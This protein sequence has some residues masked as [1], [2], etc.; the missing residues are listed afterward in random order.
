MIAVEPLQFQPEEIEILE[1]KEKPSLEVWAEEVYMIP[2]QSGA[3]NPGPWRNFYTPYLIEPMQKL[4]QVG[5]VQVTIQSCTQWGK[6]ELSNIFVCSRCELDPGPTMILMPREDDANERVNVRLRPGFRAMPKLLRHLP[7]NRAESLNSGKETVLDNMPFFIAW[8]TSPAALGNRSIRYLALDEIGK[9]PQKVGK[10]AD[11]VSLVKKRLRTFKGRWK[12]LAVSTPVVE[13]DLIDKEFKKGN[14]C[15]WWVKCPHCNQWHQLSW[16]N[17]WIEKDEKG[18]FYESEYYSDAKHSHYVC[19]DC[20]AIWTEQER[21]LAAS[22]GMWCPKNCKVVNGKVEGEIRKTKHYSYHG[23]ALMISP[24]VTTVSD[25]SQEWV[26]ANEEKKKGDKEPLQDFYNSQLGLPFYEIQGKTQEKIVLEHK[27]LYRSGFVPEYV[28]MLVNAIDVQL[29]HVYVMTLGVGYLWQSAIIFFDKLETGDTK[30]IENWGPVENFLKMQF[31]RKD[32]L[33]EIFHP[34][35]TAIDCQYNKETVINFCQKITWHRLFPVIGDDK[36]RGTLY[37]KNE[38]DD[39]PII[40]YHLNVN[41]IKNS[42]FELLHRSEIFG[43]GYMQVPE[44]VSSALVRQLCDEHRVFR[45][46]GKYKRLIWEP[47]DTNHPNNHGWDLTVYAKWLADILGA[48][49]LQQ[50]TPPPP[51]M[52]QESKERRHGGFLDNLPNLN[53]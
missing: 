16:W 13:D 37:R 41:E 29:D 25:L 53:R 27:G 20:G 30:N 11:P 18:N 43:P 1:D 38:K 48:K 35:A 50:Q 3:A 36:V 44:D 7:G 8:A 21:W 9:Y 17:V 19:P 26:L 52:P 46:E 15:E 23:H 47:K 10:E 32:R 28:Q 22:K 51:N 31:P 45:K 6:S 12:V 40:R 14:Q 24:M 5:E 39:A 34:L 2:E 49:M 33:N 4:S 42:V